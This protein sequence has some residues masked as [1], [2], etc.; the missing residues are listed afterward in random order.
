MEK[1]QRQFALWYF[2]AAFWL[3]LGIHE[4][5]IARHTETLLYSDFKVLLKAGKV[6]DLALGERIISGRLRR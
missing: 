5:L 2:I 1:K 3:V 6:E 4:F